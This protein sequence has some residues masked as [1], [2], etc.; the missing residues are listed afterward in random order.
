MDLSQVGQLGKGVLVPERDIDHSVVYKR[1]ERVRDGGLLPATLASGGD[2]D[3]THLARESGLAPERAGGVPEC[4]IGL[5]SRATSRWFAGDT[6]S[7]ARE[8]S[9]SE[10]EHQIGTRQS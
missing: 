2:E 1:G 10:W 8:S 6:P 9:R 5:L 7:T 4:L 3:A